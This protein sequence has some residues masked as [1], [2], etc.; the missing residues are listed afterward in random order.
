M[1]ELLKSGGLLVVVGVL[2]V[3]FCYVCKEEVEK[4]VVKMSNNC[5]DGVFVVFFVLCEDV[6]G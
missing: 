2:C 1:V 6:K 4:F 3:R 5:I